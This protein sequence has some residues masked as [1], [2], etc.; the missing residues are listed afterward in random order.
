[1]W[2]SLKSYLKPSPEVERRQRKMEVWCKISL[3]L[4]SYLYRFCM[5]E[6]HIHVFCT[7]KWLLEALKDP[8]T[9]GPCT[10]IYWALQLWGW[11][12]LIFFSTRFQYSVRRPF[13][14]LTWLCL[15]QWNW[16]SAITGP[17]F[18]R[19]SSRISVETASLSSRCRVVLSTVVRWWS[20]YWGPTS[21]MDVSTLST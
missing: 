12:M 8:V 2:A 21:Q 13:T 9:N 10:S 18:P 17:V 16:V 4:F 3:K 14:L 20:F 7:H 15:S 19:S 1:M 6:D 11:V 5:T